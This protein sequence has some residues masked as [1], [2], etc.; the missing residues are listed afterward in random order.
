MLLPLKYFVACA[1]MIGI[2]A[3]AAQYPLKPVRFVAP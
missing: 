1:F 2:G 3:A